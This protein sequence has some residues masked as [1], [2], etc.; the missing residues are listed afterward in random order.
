M[1]TYECVRLINFPAADEAEVL[2]Q[3]TETFST[4]DGRAALL[5]QLQWLSYGMGNIIYV[6]GRS[7]A[8]KPCTVNNK[9]QILE[10][11]HIN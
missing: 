8:G 5:K 2:P 10:L 7:S 1:A 6:H 4:P 3:L 11:T 9:G